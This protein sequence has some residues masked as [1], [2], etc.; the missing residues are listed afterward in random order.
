MQPQSRLYSTDQVS[1]LVLNNA[2]ILVL[3]IIKHYKEHQQELLAVLTI[4]LVVV[5]PQLNVVH[6]SQSYKV[7]LFTNQTCASIIVGADS[8]QR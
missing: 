3:L 2:L 6:W 5:S 8:I 7:V 1:V 4:M